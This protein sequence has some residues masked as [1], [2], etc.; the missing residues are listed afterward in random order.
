M[1]LTKYF[2]IL[3]ERRTWAPDAIAAAKRRGYLTRHIAPG[4]VMPRSMD[5]VSLHGLGF[6]RPHAH[7]AILKRNQTKDDREMRLQFTHMVQDRA[8]VEVYEN[9]SEQFRRWSALMP[10]TWRF[11][12]EGAAYTFLYNEAS[13]PLVSKADVGASSYNVRILK[14]VNDALTHLSKIFDEG[15][16]VKH[17]AGGDGIRDVASLQKDYILLQEFIPH[18]TTYRVNRVGRALAAFKRFNYPNKDVAQTGNVEPVMSID[19]EIGSLFHYARGILDQVIQ[20]K[21]V[22]LDILRDHSRDK[23]CLIETSLAWPW[24]AGALANTPFF[25]STKRKWGEMWDLMLDEYEA[26]VFGA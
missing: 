1:T 2:A 26:G 12:D 10:P 14:D 16:Y 21:W 4:N 11:T 18:T 7:P 19:D 8:Q 3:D 9:K 24:K 23:W 13:Y 5:E 20:S 6:I 25:G 22:A 17:C 15:I